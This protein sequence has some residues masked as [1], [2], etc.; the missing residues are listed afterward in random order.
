MSDTSSA[1]LT[2]FVSVVTAT[3][4]SATVLTPLNDEVYNWRDRVDEGKFSMPL[5]VVVP[6][7]EEP[8]ED[9]PAT[10]NQRIMPVDFYYVRSSQLQSGESGQASTYVRAALSTMREA[11]MAHT[12]VAMAVWPFPEID[13]SHETS[14]NDDLRQKP[15][16]YISG[17]LSS[18]LLVG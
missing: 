15:E 11:L 6:H 9:G 12:P 4:P 3:F 13:S 16:P 2:E 7:A 14:L 1:G 10:V 8:W 17:K 18:R 5:C